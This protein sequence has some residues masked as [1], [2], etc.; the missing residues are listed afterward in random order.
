MHQFYALTPDGLL[1]VPASITNQNTTAAAG[2]SSSASTANCSP[3]AAD[4]SP[5]GFFKPSE[6]EPPSQKASVDPA[7]KFLGEHANLINL[8]NLITPKPVCPVK[9]EPPKP[10]LFDLSSPTSQQS[11]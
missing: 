7:A 3:G 4:S 9:S 1:D 2:T 11:P 5:M 6:P 8:D 10:S